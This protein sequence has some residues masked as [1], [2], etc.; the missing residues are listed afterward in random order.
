M[1]R[2][3]HGGKKR[4]FL[5][6]VSK[7]MFGCAGLSRNQIKAVLCQQGK[8]EEHPSGFLSVKGQTGPRNGEEEEEGGGGRVAHSRTA[9]GDGLWEV[10]C[11]TWK[12]LSP[13]TG[14]NLPQDGQQGCESHN[15]GIRQGFLHT[16]WKEMPRAL[17]KKLL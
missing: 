17:F 11:D 9:D 2:S 13:F 16:V 15:P 6:S 14:V 1:S 10:G 5:G 7:E 3:E 12:A 4:G 8:K